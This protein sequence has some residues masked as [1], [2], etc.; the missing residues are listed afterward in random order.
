MQHVDFGVL[1]KIID[2][3]GGIDLDISD[4]EYSLINPLIDEQNSVTGSDSEYISGPGYQHVNG[5]QATAYARTERL[6]A[7]SSVLNA[8]ESFYPRFLK[9]PNQRISEHC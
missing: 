4:A 6:T 2:A 8:S 1:A 5:T 7:T 3:V 9:K